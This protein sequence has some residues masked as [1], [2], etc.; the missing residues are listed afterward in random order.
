[1]ARSLE[2]LCYCAITVRASDKLVALCF[3][4]SSK[5]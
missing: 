4:L 1:V 2:L 5:M 3:M